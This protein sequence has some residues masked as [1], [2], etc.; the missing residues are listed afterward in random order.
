MKEVSCSPR[1]HLF[2]QKYI[3]KRNIMKYC[4]NWK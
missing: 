2:D 1:M 3:E 4:S